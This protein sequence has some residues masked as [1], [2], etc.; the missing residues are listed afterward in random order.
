MKTYGYVVKQKRKELGLTLE[1]VAKRAGTHKGYVSGIENGKVN[2]PSPKTTAKL[3]RILDLDVRSL[4][5]LAWVGKAPKAIK[6]LVEQRI[7]EVYF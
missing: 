3:A 6:G 2:P 7:G 4:M 5:L 1:K